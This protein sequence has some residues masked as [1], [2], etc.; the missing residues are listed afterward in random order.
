MLKNYLTCSIKRYI[1]FILTFYIVTGTD[2][3]RFTS[4][5]ILI[6]NYKRTEPLSPLEHKEKE[7][8]QV[9]CIILKS[10]EKVYRS[11]KM[12]KGGR[13]FLKTE[14][15]VSFATI[16]DYICSL[17]LPF[18]F[19]LNFRKK[20]RSRFA[21]KLIKFNCFPS[22][23]YLSLYWSCYFR[24]VINDILT[25]YIFIFELFIFV[26]YVSRFRLLCVWIKLVLQSRIHPFTHPFINVYNID[27]FKD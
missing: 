3:L 6:P 15:K 25:N 19:W 16:N 12:M 24:K 14:G 5:K 27:N 7:K 9:S 21:C 18:S 22:G 10:K 2:K 23:F 4:G 20:E 11:Q 17:F 1:H 8:L 13:N 26:Q